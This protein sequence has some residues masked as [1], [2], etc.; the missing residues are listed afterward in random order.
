MESEKLKSRKNL[1]NIYFMKKLESVKLKK[2]KMKK[3]TGGAAID[4]YTY[5]HDYTY[6]GGVYVHDTVIT[7]VNT[8]GV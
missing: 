3:V 1:S 6:R 7:D 5:G 8:A 2:F 4:P